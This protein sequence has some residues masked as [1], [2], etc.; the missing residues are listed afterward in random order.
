MIPQDRI[1]ATATSYDSGES[2]TPD[3]ANDDNTN[4]YWASSATEDNTVT[5][6]YLTY[7][8]G[9]SYILNKFQY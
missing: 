2:A 8:L 9:S 5:S 3:R 7:D 4:T 6:Q 1:T